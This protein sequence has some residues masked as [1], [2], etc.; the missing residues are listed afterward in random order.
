MKDEVKEKSVKIL[1][2]IFVSGKTIMFVA[3]AMF[4]LGFLLGAILF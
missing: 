3:W 2:A 4:L 1:E